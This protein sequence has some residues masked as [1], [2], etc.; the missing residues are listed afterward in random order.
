MAATA[1][2]AHAGIYPRPYSRKDYR[3]AGVLYFVGAGSPPE[4]INI[5][6]TTSQRLLGRL[7]AI[8]RTNHRDPVLL[9]I[10]PFTYGQTLMM[11]A[12]RYQA[13]LHEH[14]ASIQ[15]RKP[16]TIGAGWF[17][18]TPVLLEFIATVADPLSSVEKFPNPEEILTVY[19]L[20]P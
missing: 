16:G 13:E 9:G 17:E 10:V 20:S 6:V 7:R 2:A 15:L 1:P 4:A 14:F 5:G 3:K 19:C 8:H 11:D 18:A 12:E